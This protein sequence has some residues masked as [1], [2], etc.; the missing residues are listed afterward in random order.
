[1]SKK[2]YRDAINECLH[3][4]MAR[5]PSIIVLGEDVVGGS[6]TPGG[7]EAIGGVF[8]LTEGL[9]AKFGDERVIDT[10][11]SESA[12]VG[13]A[14]GAALAGLRPVAEIM[15][16]DFLGLCLDPLYNQAAKFKYMFGG[17][18]ATP[19]VVRT[20]IG[21]GMNAA[22]QHSQSNYAWTTSIPGLKSALPSTPADAK[23][24]LAAAI[25]G[26]D[27]VVFFEH[28]MLYALEGDVPDEPF[29]IPLGKGSLIRSGTDATVVA[30][31]RM[32]H[33]AASAVDRLGAEGIRCDLI[34]P[35]T[36]S[37]LDEE[38]ICDSVAQTGRLIVV[39]ESPP[40]CGLA[41][42]VA[43]LVSSR[44][45]DFLDSPIQLVTPPH[46]PIPFAPNLE[47]LYIPT[48]KSIESAIRS[49]LQGL[50]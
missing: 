3:Q 5:D 39:D 40:R 2:S 7:K 30:F 12:I 28:K 44:A 26:D 21:A 35:R 46:T 50:S 24:L 4:E 41:R 19:M 42:D 14:A 15:F 6:G 32:V 25:R 45:F 48:E 11:I 8:S 9:W 33:L 13:A 36:T 18:A 38:L 37:P 10:P 1:M 43:G 31:S 22:A 16:C 20:T 23:G 47:E 34:D 49:A 27:P 17:K 29:L